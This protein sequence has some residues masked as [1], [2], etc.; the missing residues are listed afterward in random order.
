MDVM[1]SGQP[2]SPWCGAGRT[3]LVA[4]AVV[5]AAL[6]PLSSGAQQLPTLFQSGDEQPT[7]RADVTLITN[8]VIVRDGSGQF[9]SDLTK[10]D[11]VIEED[12]VRQE[13]ASLVLIQGGR[14]FNLQMPAA[15]PVAEGIIL[16]TARPRNDTAGRVFMLFVDDL[17]MEADETPRIRDLFKRIAKNL[18]HEG[19][20]FSIVSSGPSSIAIDLTYDRA[21]LDAAI[22][23]IMG[24]GMTPTD[25]IRGPQGSRGPSELFYRANVAVATALDIIR[26][27]QQ[28]EHRR[29]AIIYVSAGYDLNPFEESRFAEANTFGGGRF[30]LDQLEDGGQR[31]RTN[32]F[33]EQTNYQFSDL[34]LSNHLNR[35]VR[36]ANRANATFYT[37]DPRGLIA[38]ADIGEMEGQLDPTQWWDYVRK[39]Q[40]SLRTLAEGTGGFA[41]VN[42]N[43][44]DNALRRIDAETSDYYVIGY[45]SNNS[46][47]AQWRRRLAI[48]VTRD[49]VDVWS[50]TGYELAEPEE[51][52]PPR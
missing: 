50:R 15:A 1:T 3:G 48:T 35:L 30:R 31:V 20:L 36:A 12:G 25:I 49:G 27:L 24:N 5:A 34:D 40:A 39:S 10:D 47:P 38:G 13:L 8:D 22:G 18:V 7:F 29:K 4:V 37:I 41:V 44:F 21:L 16:P 6:L 26:V 2:S 17:H 23:K 46:D 33:M 52:E 51:T 42:R 14:A 45:Y 9:V 19:D 32:P 28:L 43:N 11:F